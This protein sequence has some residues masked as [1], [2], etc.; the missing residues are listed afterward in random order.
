MQ[1]APFVFFC[2]PGFESDC[3]AEVQAIANAYE[4]AGYAN[5]PTDSG[6]VRFFLFDEES[7]EQF[8]EML[9]LN[10][11]VFARQWFWAKAELQDLP[12]EDRISPIIEMSSGGATGN[13]VLVEHLD[14]DEGRELS[15]FCKKFSTPLTIAL[16]KQ[17]L[18][19]EDSEFRLHILFLANDHCLVGYSP[20]ERSSELKGGILRLKSPRH[21]PS[22]STLKLDE[23]IQV[24]MSKK[25]QKQV[26]RLGNTAADL[27]AAPGGWTFQLVERGLQVSAVDN[28]P[29][30]KKLMATEQVEHFK[31]NAFN[32]FPEKPVDLVVCDMVEKPSL[33]ANLM[34]SWLEEQHAQQAIFNLKLPMKKRFQEVADCIGLICDRLEEAE[35]SYHWQAKHLY[36]DREEITVYFRVK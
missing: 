22:R 7:A 13:S 2:R 35:L 30:D 21:A 20:V 11:I 24:L 1:Q 14:S 23:A 10:D 27:G 28:G 36:H 4:L 12:L 9:D 32:W 31:A 33:V 6:Y 3:A 18:I 25:Q 19:H 17:G 8:F 16:E 5:A 26:F 29:M 34:A 15:K